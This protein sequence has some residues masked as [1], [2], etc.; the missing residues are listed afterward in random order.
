MTDKILLKAENIKK[1]YRVSAGFLK[2]KDKK[3]VDDVSLELHEGETLGLVGESG[4]GKTTLGKT[5]IHLIPATEG[6]V[7]FDGE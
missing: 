5:L 7:Y 6:K 4:C 2:K 1:Y 3:I